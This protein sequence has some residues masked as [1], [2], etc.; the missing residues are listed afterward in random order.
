[1]RG[2]CNCYADDTV[3]YAG[4]DCSITLCTDPTH[5]YNPDDGTCSGTCPPG[6][7]PNTQSR[8]CFPCASQCG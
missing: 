1:M 8:T 5:F 6:T 4:E 2:I 3:S 7:Y